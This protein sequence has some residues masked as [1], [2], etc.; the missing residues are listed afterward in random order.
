M[1]MSARFAIVG[2]I[3]AAAIDRAAAAEPSEPPVQAAAAD[4]VVA[5]G[6]PAVPATAPTAPA[7][8]PA[9]LPSWLSHVDLSGVAFLFYRYELT[10]GAKDFNTFDVGRMYFRADIRPM[11][12]VKFRMTLDAPG[13]EPTT[14]VQGGVTTVNKDAGKFDV[15]LKHA[16]GELYDVLVPGLSLKFG[17]HD[18]PWVPFVEAIWGYRFQ[19]TVFSDREGYLSSTDLGV[20]ASYVLPGKWVE[21]YFSLVNGETWSKPEVSKHKDVHGRITLR[22]LASHKVLSGLSLSVLGAAGRYDSGDDQGRYR[23]IPQLAFEHKHAAI[24]V[25]Y[26]WA[27]DVPGKLVSRHPSLANST[28]SMVTA[29]GLS[30]FA[31]LDFGM[32][33]VA[34]GLRLM[35]RLDWLDPDTD[36]DQN[37]HTREIAGLGYRASKHVE[38]LADLELVQYDASALAAADE[39]RIFLHTRVGF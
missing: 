30:A 20:A 39:K 6:P 11:E 34:D 7:T 1:T 38:V 4:P 31:W 2:L 8:A 32:F 27:Q 9:A 3:V 33:G 26:L 13:R 5:A 17:M 35:A 16:Y 29:G 14:T 21:A 22:P 18:L 15:V 23:F 36:L 10:D 24:A 28:D 37:S 19:G 25:E 12:H